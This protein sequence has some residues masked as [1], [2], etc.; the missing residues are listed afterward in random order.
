MFE[1][2]ESSRAAEEVPCR[3]VPVVSVQPYGPGQRP[4][5]AP[6]FSDDPYQSEEEQ[7]YVREMSRPVRGRVFST[8]RRDS[9]S[10]SEEDPTSEPEPE[11]SVPET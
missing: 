5:I 1:R 8:G 3:D 2:G 7:P 11:D 9:D 6:R 4:V 10:E